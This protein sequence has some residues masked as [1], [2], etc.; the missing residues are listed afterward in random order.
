M[1]NAFEEI[2]AEMADAGVTADFIERLRKASEGSPLRKQIDE[3]TKERDGLLSENGKYRADSLQARF[4][5]LGIR[6]KPDALKIPD[7]LDPLDEKK[8]TEWA[9]GMGLI[10]QPALS[11]EEQ[12]LADDLAAQDRIA[13]AGAGAPPG[14]GAGAVLTPEAVAEWPM[15]K[16][17]RFKQ[18]F[19]AEFEAIKRGEQVRN[20]QFA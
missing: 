15:D 1:P 16:T 18:Q 8:V 14:P 7:D 12:Q 13:A 17:V 20:T 4:D 3:L 5:A 6:I 19:P 10:D 2:L 11:E 9:V